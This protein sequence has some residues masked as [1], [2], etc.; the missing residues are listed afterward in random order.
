MNQTTTT[1]HTND[2]NPAP[3]TPLVS[4]LNHAALMTSDLDR[5]VA[6]YVDV[7]DGEYL[8]TPAPPGM[9]AATVRLSATSGLALLEMPDNAHV[10][11]S[12]AMADRGHIDHI[13]LEAPTPA[14][15]EAVRQRLVAAGACDG[16]VS[17][18]GA[19]FS[20]YFVDPDG[21]GCEVC[22][23]RDPSFTDTHAP[24]PF[25]GDLADLA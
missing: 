3:T 17:D 22:W 12:T 2:P 19:L 14:A 25:T 15:L 21:M 1:T 20:V 7:F 23:I 10:A 4:G 11:G 18:Y 6:F 16:T 5:L 8:Q 24:V 9:R 13:A